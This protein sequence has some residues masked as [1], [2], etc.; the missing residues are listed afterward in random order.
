MF[1]DNELQMQSLY[2]LS[3]PRRAAIMELIAQRGALSVGEIAK[4]FDISGAAVSQHLKVLKDAGLVSVETHGQHRIYTIRVEAIDEIADWVRDIK[5][6][7]N[8]QLDRLAEFLESGKDL[9][10]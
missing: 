4:N 3:E 8:A 10:S 5:Y 6:K 7:M 9:D 2:A 1:V